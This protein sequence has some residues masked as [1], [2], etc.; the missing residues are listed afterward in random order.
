MTAVS[1]L[2]PGVPPSNVT[3]TNSKHVELLQNLKGHKFRTVHPTQKQIV[4]CV[5]PLNDFTHQ[6]FKQLCCISNNRNFLANKNPTL[7][8]IE[9]TRKWGPHFYVVLAVF[10]IFFCCLCLCCL[11]LKRFY[12]FAL[13]GIMYISQLIHKAWTPIGSVTAMA[14]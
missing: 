7:K 12:M 5:P 2:P 8:K 6:V 13:S 1:T 11:F 10:F 14:V 4:V 9:S 3:V